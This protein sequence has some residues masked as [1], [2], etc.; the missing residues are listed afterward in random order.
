MPLSSNERIEDLMDQLLQASDY[1]QFW[2]R[3]VVARQTSDYLQIFYHPTTGLEKETFS[4]SEP[5]QLL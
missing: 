4:F 2:T 5:P 1:V 3:M